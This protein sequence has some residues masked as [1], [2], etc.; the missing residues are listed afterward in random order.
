MVA[1]QLSQSLNDIGDI[2]SDEHDGLAEGTE[3]Q[4][5]PHGISISTVDDSPGTCQARTTHTDVSTSGLEGLCDI[6][7]ADVPGESLGC[8]D[9]FCKEC[10]K[11]MHPSTH[12]VRRLVLCWYNIRLF[13][14]K[15]LRA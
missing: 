2:L 7:E 11:V 1:G 3:S 9:K 12:T 4:A 8:G 13:I 14:R 10:L 15:F 5:Q 6:C